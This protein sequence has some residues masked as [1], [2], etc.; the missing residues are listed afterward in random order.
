MTYTPAWRSAAFGVLLLFFSL[1]AGGLRAELKPAV[2]AVVD[3]QLVMQTAVASRGIQTAIESQREVYAREISNLETKLRTAEQELTQQRSGLSAE[4][5]A[6][7]RRVFEQQLAEVQRTV[8]ARKRQL[9]RAFNEAMSKVRDSLLQT[10]A[11]VAR[12]VGAT[13]VLSKQQVVI[14]EKSI[15]LTDTVL[16][17][18]NKK[19]P[20]VSVSVE[21]RE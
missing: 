10:V 18:L 17:R 8:Q 21:E 15:D 9:D 11:E 14:I 5:F 4:E 3:V 20:S 2:L 16:D 19:L 1:G 7:R 6:N 12:E 13:V